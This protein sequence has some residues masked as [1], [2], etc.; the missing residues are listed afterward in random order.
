[1]TGV[2]ACTLA[3]I[4]QQSCRLPLAAAMGALTVRSQKEQGKASLR[5]CGTQYNAPVA[6]HLR[7]IIGSCV[8]RNL[9]SVTARRMG[10]G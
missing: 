10:R 6:V 8:C 9:R 1:M 7:C 4:G 2:T 5:L 3:V